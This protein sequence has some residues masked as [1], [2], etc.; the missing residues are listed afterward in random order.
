MTIRR[1][2]ML[3]SI[4]LICAIASAAWVYSYSRKCHGVDACA[5]QSAEGHE[6]DVPS[7][8]Q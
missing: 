4:A 3:L 5:A 7:E 6:R 8:P 2:Y 1:R